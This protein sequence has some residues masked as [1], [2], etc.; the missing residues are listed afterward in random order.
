MVLR[1]FAERY[2]ELNRLAR[3]ADPSVPALSE[4]VAL[5]LVGAILELVA[6]RVEDGR[7]E[8]LPELADTLTEFVTRNAVAPG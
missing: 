2:L 7:T 4:D 3:E 8:A 1:I 5:G 6:V